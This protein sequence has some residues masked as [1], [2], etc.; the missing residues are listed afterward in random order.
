MGR[1][2]TCVYGVT[3]NAPGPDGA[4]GAEAGRTHLNHHHPEGAPMPTVRMYA[5]IQGF[6]DA[7]QFIGAKTAAY[8]SVGNAFPPGMAKAVGIAIRDALGAARSRRRINAGHVGDIA[9]GASW[10]PL[11]I[12]R[13]RRSSKATLATSWTPENA[14]EITETLFVQSTL[15]S[16]VNNHT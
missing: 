13:L 15:A 1:L 16:R 4:D 3:D 5:R 12:T 2:G 14:L 6:P 11:Q 8:R 9:S 10:T 7:W